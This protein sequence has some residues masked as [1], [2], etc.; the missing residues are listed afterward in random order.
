[1]TPKRARG[2]GESALSGDRR[3]EILTEAAGAAGTSWAGLRREAL[4]RDGRQAVGGWPGTISEARGY[5]ASFVERRISS[6][7]S[8]DELAWV[9]RA[10][11]ESA[12]REWLSW[13]NE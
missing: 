4:K 7:L 11:Y 13:Q 12:R 2:A 1:M 9:A 6:V 8:R 3:S 10:T 5:A